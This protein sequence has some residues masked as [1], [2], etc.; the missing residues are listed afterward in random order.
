MRFLNIVVV[1]LVL[2]TV[3]ACAKPTDKVTALISQLSNG[4]VDARAG[5]I[6]RLAE[7][8]DARAI[9]PLIKALGDK[10]PYVRS[11]TASS[12]CNIPDMRVTNALV[13]ALSDKDSN[14]RLEAA[15]SLAWLG[16]PAAVKP[17]LAL[18]R[19]QGDPDSQQAAALSHIGAPA[20][21]E[22]LAAVKDPS[23]A[24]RACAA[25]ALV[26]VDNPKATSALLVIL[27]ADKNKNVRLNAVRAL[28]RKGRSEPVRDLLKLFTDNRE[29]VAVRCESAAC[30]G[31]IG[32]NRAVDPLLGS[33]S[34]KTVRVQVAS[35]RAL[36]Q[37]HDP[38]AAAQILRLLTDLES[39]SAS[40]EPDSPESELMR[41]A[42]QALP[43][44]G[45]ATLD[46]LTSML[47]TGSTN[48]KN[49]ALMVLSQMKDS[50]ALEL[51]IQTLQSPDPKMRYAAAESLEMMDSPE[52]TAALAVAL[53]DTDAAVRDAALSFYCGADYRAI[54]DCRAAVEPLAELT[55]SKDTETK[56]TAARGLRRL[57]PEKAIDPLIE[58]LCSS[59]SQHQRVFEELASMM[60]IS[61]G[62]V[63]E[64][65]AKR[66]Q[67]RNMVPFLINVIKRSGRDR[68]GSD[69]ARML[70]LTKDPRSVEPLILLLKHRDPEV[71][72]DA[73]DALG[74]LGDKRA[75][76]ALLPLVHT[77]DRHGVLDALVSIERQG[78]VPQL[79]A[80]LQNPKESTD[81]HLD[82]A[83][84]LAR[85]GDGRGI[86]LLIKRLKSKDW[87]DRQ[88]AA[89]DLGLAH[90]EAAVKA[91]SAALNDEE[92]NVR[93]AAAGALA[94]IGDASAE[95]VLVNALNRW[96][97]EVI[98][99]AFYF[100]IGRGTED[101]IPEI[102][103]VAT[104][105]MG[106]GN[107]GPD[108]AS[109]LY[110]SGRPELVARAKEW[111][112]K[113]PDCPFF[114]KPIGPGVHY[115]KW[116]ELKH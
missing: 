78:A 30:L 70:G 68:M 99:G 33:L 76:P 19:A 108:F 103:D 110:H 72:R 79:T 23:P 85:L 113:N 53:R 5:V 2:T 25:L 27:A 107:D 43:A 36:Q 94:L 12:L 48:D 38:R 89:W 95:R 17:I 26:S 102:L 65:V 41:A 54:K 4:S 52:A 97:P 44:F 18:V 63:T 59:G 11:A 115:Y 93:C 60:P 32:D 71:R 92:D 100:Y 9:A 28:G 105:D 109:A 16:D 21:A 58:I 45:T 46:P 7:T 20:L 91:L 84:R 56:L 31:E 55:K 15:R 35:I 14:V 29:D 1:V 77:K 6:R 83:Q 49:I 37:L 69:A 61:G 114:E 104:A 62:P 24:V 74:L 39:R 66:L 47:R 81:A 67:E 90:G 96:D 98:S 22:L 86:P 3:S 8:E 51:L 106:Q 112:A 87:S 50:R 75:I 116:G 73:L 13:L 64:A 82:A 88:D 42:R 101:A 57:A 111:A 10:D 34:S 40:I 80:I